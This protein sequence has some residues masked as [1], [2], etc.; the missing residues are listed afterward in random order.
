MNKNFKAHC[1]QFLKTHLIGVWWLSVNNLN[2]GFGASIGI[3]F[4]VRI[5]IS[6]GPCWAI[7]MQNAL[8]DPP[9]PCGPYPQDPHP[10]EKRRAAATGLLLGQFCVVSLSF[11]KVEFICPKEPPCHSEPDSI[12]NSVFPLSVLPNA[13]YALISDTFLGPY[14]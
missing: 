5:I 12:H 14:R 8:F 7:F 11:F 10:S 3:E 1:F 6:M 13:K 9:A 2:L 4:G